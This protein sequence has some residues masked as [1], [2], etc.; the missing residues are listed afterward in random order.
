MSHEELLYW[1][2]H[3]YSRFC[4]AQNLETLLAHCFSITQE[5]NFEFFSYDFSEPTPFS[6]PKHHTFG[7]YPDKKPDN[8]Q[9]NK[10]S[11]LNK[12]QHLSE[13]HGTMSFF[14]QISLM[15][16]GA[17]EY[18]F[19]ARSRCNIETL[20]F[21]QLCL[22]VKILTEQFY[23]KLIELNSV[24]LPIQRPCLSLREREILLWSADGKTSEE[25]AIILGIS[26]DAVN[27]LHKKIQKKMGVKNRAQAIAYAIVRGYL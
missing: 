25:T 24:K 4:S 22:K 21:D 3:L 9:P 19:L 26:H 27:F 12:T 1:D 18:F 2:T 14:T 5:L 23:K 8:T 15:P 16:E 11:S 17:I 7:N 6:N 20:E 13:H 10:R